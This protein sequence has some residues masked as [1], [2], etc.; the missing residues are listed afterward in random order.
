LIICD[1][2]SKR[3]I[4]L[5]HIILFLNWRASLFKMT[6]L[7]LRGRDICSLKGRTFLLN[8]IKIGSLFALMWKVDIFSSNFTKFSKKKYRLFTSKQKVIRF[9]FYLEE[10]FCLWENIYPSPL[11]VKWSIPKRKLKK[12][13]H[14]RKCYLFPISITYLF[15]FLW[16]I[17]YWLPLRH[18]ITF[19]CSFDYSF[20]LIYVENYVDTRNRQIQANISNVNKTW[21]LLQT[22]RGKVEP[23]QSTA[24]HKNVL[25]PTI[26]WCS[27][28]IKRQ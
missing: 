25:L 7:L 28:H 8:K 11:R 17:H 10:M 23:N 18:S 6:T 14:F 12:R 5:W 20:H 15:I 22:T 4:K 27:I 13:K 16:V 26:L 3:I 9:L 21:T 19:I 2:H 24:N 1:F